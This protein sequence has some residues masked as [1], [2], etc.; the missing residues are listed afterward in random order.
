MHPD[1]SHYHCC[2]EF[3]GQ[4]KDNKNGLSIADDDH[5]RGDFTNTEDKSSV[6]GNRLKVHKVVKRSFNFVDQES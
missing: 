3:P 4:A 6:E 1:N 5:S 2:N